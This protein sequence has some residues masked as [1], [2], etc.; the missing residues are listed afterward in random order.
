MSYFNSAD[1]CFGF[2]DENLERARAPNLSVAEDETKPNQS[3]EP[4]SKLMKK[5]EASDP[6]VFRLF[7]PYNKTKAT[8]LMLYI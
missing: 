3:V 5:I 1:L 4:I 8:Q 7:C 6:T 2:E